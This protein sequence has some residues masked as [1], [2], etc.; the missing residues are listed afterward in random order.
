MADSNPMGVRPAVALT[1]PARDIAFLRSTVTMT[2]EG[3]RDEL[4]R[5]ADQLQDPERLRAE[6][7]AYER[8]LT[9]LDERGS[10]LTPSCVA[11]SRTWPR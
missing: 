9:A 1:I 4:A 3:V 6:C 10:S 7:A 2:Q 11:C 5:F 8:I